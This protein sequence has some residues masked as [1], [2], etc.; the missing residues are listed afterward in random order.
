MGDATR[1]RSCWH[2]R[3]VSPRVDRVFS[4]G[5]LPRGRPGFELFEAVI[6]LGND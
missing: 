1:K 6:V 5:V 2:R 3:L 4:R